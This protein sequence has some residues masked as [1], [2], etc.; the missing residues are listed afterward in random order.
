VR[1]WPQ[2]APLIPDLDITILRENTEGFYPDRN[3][4]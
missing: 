2:L 1:A 3:L 4:A